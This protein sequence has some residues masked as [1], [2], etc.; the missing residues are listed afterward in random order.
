M[1]GMQRG[2]PG[3][4]LAL[5][6]SMPHQ[7]QTTPLWPPLVGPAGLSAAEYRSEAGDAY[8]RPNSAVALTKVSRGHDF[9]RRE[10]M[11]WTSE[12]F[13]MPKDGPDLRRL[14]SVAARVLAYQDHLGEEACHVTSRT[15][16][17]KL[18]NT[19]ANA[20]ARTCSTAQPVNRSSR[21][22]EMCSNVAGTLFF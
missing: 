3:P 20:N 8:S 19:L 2:G 10:Y 7:R 12:I 1:V 11:H 6:L 4:P 13:H 5:T 16:R 22:G 15:Q 9:R 18:P 14:T 21:S 17:T